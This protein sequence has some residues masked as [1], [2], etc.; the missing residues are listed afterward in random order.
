M[1]RDVL[2]MR[3]M[4]VLLAAALLAPAS[5][6]LPALTA[7]KAGS[8]GWLA[9]LCALPLLLIALWAV[10]G[11]VREMGSCRAS[12]GILSAIIIIVYL[13]WTLLLLALAL[14]L[15]AV[16]LAVLYGERAALGCAAALLAAAVWMGLGKTGALARAGEVFYL[17]LAV[18]L[19][20]VLFLAAFH[21]EWKNL[22]PSAEE[23]AA[24]PGSGAAAAGLLLN[25]VPAAVLGKRVR[26]RS[27]NGR[28]AVGWTAAFCA[29]V[30][31]LL[32]AV[33]GCVGPRLTTRL[34]APFL[35]MVQGLGIEGAFQRTE[36]LFAALWTL[37]DLTLVGLLLHTWR[38]LAGRL[39]S[40]R[41]SRWS[42]LP[43]AAAAIIGG[44]TLFDTVEGM[45]AFCGEILP[46]IGL[47][48][49]LAFPLLIGIL[50]WLGKGKGE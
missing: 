12:G 25:I 13:I 38:E 46:V 5:D 30:T 48:L 3:Q 23:M 37:S 26:T 9:V 20:A 4:M 7:E 42:I 18:A 32:G 15:S 45:R 1:E 6:L 40:G 16:R 22:W 44:W 27:Q 2:S 49:G 41:W 24:L 36:A 50:R 28:R 19:A 43:A 8:G 11:A 39:H 47:T 29:A 21:V 35:T 10:G 31:L 33:I 14:R 34:P 17:A